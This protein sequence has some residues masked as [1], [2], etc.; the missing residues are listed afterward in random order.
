MS[1]HN[2]RYGNRDILLSSC[3]TIVKDSTHVSCLQYL[4]ADFIRQVAVDNYQ[5]REM[6]LRLKC[7][8]QAQGT[9]FGS[10]THKKA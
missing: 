9:E 2:S 6:S 1:V 10:V 5:A 3:N 8:L 7:F 4:T